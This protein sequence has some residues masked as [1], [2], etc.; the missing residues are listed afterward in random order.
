MPEFNHREPCGFQKLITMMSGEY[1][2][3]RRGFSVSLLFPKIG[4][5]LVRGS[6]EGDDLGIG[7]A[8]EITGSYSLNAQPME[9]L[10]SLGIY[11]IGYKNLIK[12]GL[13]YEGLG[14][15][16]CSSARCD[17]GIIGLSSFLLFDILFSLTR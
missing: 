15:T 10:G 1:R 17:Q 13:S 16:P 3:A 12:E 9:V 14:T 8:Q 2:S 5:R 7:Q 4:V 6:S 11:W